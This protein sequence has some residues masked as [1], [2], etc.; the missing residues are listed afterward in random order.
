MSDNER[1]LPLEGEPMGEALLGSGYGAGHKEIVSLVP[2][3]DSA[4][5]GTPVA[6]ADTQGTMSSDPSDNSA[7]TQS[8]GP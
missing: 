7:P 4:G 3:P 6:S 2:P 8:E 1:D 5:L